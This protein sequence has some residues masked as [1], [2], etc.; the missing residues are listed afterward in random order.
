MQKREPNYTLLTSR[1][2]AVHLDLSPDAVNA[3]ARSRRLRG[4]KVG[5]QWRFKKRDV[6]LLKKHLSRGLEAA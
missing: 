4:T 1:E 5:R 2:A 6:T 3:M